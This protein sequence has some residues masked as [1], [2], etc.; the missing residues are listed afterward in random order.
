MRRLT[1]GRLSI[2][3][4]ARDIW[5]GVYVAESAVYV[6][7]LPLLVVKV[8]RLHTGDQRFFPQFVAAL[9][10][11]TSVSGAAPGR[12]LKPST[13]RVLSVLLF[14]AAAAALLLPIVR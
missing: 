13:V 8:K 10:R 3:L 4:D 1:F 7:P 2:Y 12:Q 6:C 14:A 9:A 11:D 5:I